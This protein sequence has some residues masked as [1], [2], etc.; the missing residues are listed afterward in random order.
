MKFLA[1]GVKV[2]LSISVLSAAAAFAAPNIADAAAAFSRTKTVTGT[3]SVTCPSGWRVTGGGYSLAGSSN[4][5][6]GSPVTVIEN[7]PVSSTGWRAKA[8]RLTSETDGSGSLYWRA[9][10]LDVSVYAVCVR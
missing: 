3:N 1:T 7:R 4:S 8:I 5:L 6:Y 9:S 2:A 10:A